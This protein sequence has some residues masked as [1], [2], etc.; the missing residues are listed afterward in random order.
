MDG[1]SSTTHTYDNNTNLLDYLF[2]IRPMLHPPVWTIVILGY[3]YV[4][5]GS[6]SVAK[7]IFLL[8]VSSAVAGW[9]YI[10]NQISDIESDRINDKLYFLPQGIIPIRSAHIMAGIAVCITL[11]GGF[12]LG[13]TIG[14]LYALGLALGYIYSA[15][16]FYAK[17][18]PLAS[19]LANGLAHGPL[20]FLIGYIGAGGTFRNGLVPSIPYFFAVAAVFV[21]T[22]IPDIEGDSRSGKITPGVA[23]GVRPA[24]VAMILS[25]LIS[26]LLASI[27]RDW[28]LAVVAGLSLPFY[29]FAL[30]R[31]N[32]RRAVI[33][34]KI[35]ILLLSIA[36]CIRFWPYAIVLTVLFAI[37]R[38]YYRKRFGMAYP[39]L[40]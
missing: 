22:T 15:G 29:T 24:I 38:L 30:I 9:A 26:F 17:N 40:T 19:V 11:T 25:L 13:R 1:T 28:P 8:I 33:S 37:T 34:I 21:G 2:F 6:A 27:T 5:P 18:H 23:L 16:P 3:Y 10:I 7:L 36:A 12:I 4:M 20:L 31:S 39:N 14:L 35:S 32:E